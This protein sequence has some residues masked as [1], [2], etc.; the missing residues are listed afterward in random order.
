MKLHKALA[1]GMAALT[2]GS[3][4][5]ACGS[6]GSSAESTTQAAA[7]SSTQAESADV[8]I[9]NSYDNTDELAKQF[10][11]KYPTTIETTM[12]KNIQN[13]LLT[14]FA[15]WNKGYEAWKAWGDILYTE[16]SLYNL[17]G[18]HMT[19][20][21]YQ[22]S[23]QA[24]LAASD[25]Q[26]GNFNL[27]LVCG[28]WC[29]INY[30][31]SNTD[32]E[33]GEKT[34][35]TVTEFVH[36]KDYGE[37][38]GTRVVEG[39]ACSK[40]SPNFETMQYFQSEESIA[41][42]NAVLESVVNYELP[43]TDDLEEKYVVMNETP[44]HGDMAEQIRSEI[45]NDFENWNQGSE[46]WETHAKEY[47]SDDLTYLQKD[48]TELSLDEYIET[49]KAQIEDEQLTR[50]YFDNMLISDDWAGIH[51]RVTTVNE[52]GEKEASDVMQFLHFVEDGD[53]LKVDKVITK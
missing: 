18:A 12:E 33:S 29:A 7:E 36:F 50:L 31:F 19:L 23:Q 25:I 30:D 47:F 38:L 49:A 26:M 15:N 42:Q 3:G 40:T 4:L 2:L 44:D 24:G 37:D 39:W 1:V 52:D 9:I 5:A 28:D 46:T 43:D 6:S 20:K 32:R 14:G 10:T 45:L 41:E 34:D 17:H 51:Y 8:D 22:A 16:D 27:M 53:S 21:E 13:R 11:V 35:G 48:G